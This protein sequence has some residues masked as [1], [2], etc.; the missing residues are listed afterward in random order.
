MLAIFLQR[1]MHSTFLLIT[2]CLCCAAYPTYIYNIAY[3]DNDNCT[4]IPYEALLVADSVC[5]SEN[6]A[7]FIGVGNGGAKVKFWYAYILFYIY[8]EKKSSHCVLVLLRG[9]IALLVQR[10]HHWKQGFAILRS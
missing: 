1:N 10:A 4:G 8:F 7:S 9:L 3:Y 5:W 2:L 6:A